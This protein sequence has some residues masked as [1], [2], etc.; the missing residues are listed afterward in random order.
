MAEE[1]TA[2]ELMQAQLDRLRE[3]QPRLVLPPDDYEDPELAAARAEGLAAM[4]AG[5]WLRIIPSRFVD[6]TLEGLDG[7]QARALPQL[8]A[9]ARHQ[10]GRNL[11]I[12]GPVGTGKS[13][14]A[15]AVVRHAF[16]ERGADVAWYLVAKL[17]DDLRPSGPLDTLDD[18]IDVDLLVLDDLGAEKASEWTAE[19]LY[20]LVA[21]RWSQERPTV[22]TTNLDSTLAAAVGPRLFS[23]LVGSS[24]VV[25][26]LAGKDR[27]MG[28]PPAAQ[29]G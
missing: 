25:V 18:L 9:W 3:R 8:D 17:L 11:V 7:E 15:A 24:A 22:V 19:R 12:T 4:R 13:H 10:A 5:R 29:R 1:P 23:R 6:A 20:V 26:R 27:R 28:P 14:A 21:E 16:M 2:G